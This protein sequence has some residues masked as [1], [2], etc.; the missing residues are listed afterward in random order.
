MRVWGGP[1]TWR[2]DGDVFKK[3]IGAGAGGERDRMS[4]VRSAPG[5]RHE[6]EGTTGDDVG[7]R[8]NVE[9]ILGTNKDHFICLTLL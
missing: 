4:S 5:Q 2:H 3:V 6:S 7:R 9:A 1:S 8:E